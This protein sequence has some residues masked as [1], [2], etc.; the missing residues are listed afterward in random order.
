MQVAYQSNKSGQRILTTNVPMRLDPNFRESLL[1][2]QHETYLD[3]SA[4]CLMSVTQ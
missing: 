1:L 4:S 3:K 2:Q